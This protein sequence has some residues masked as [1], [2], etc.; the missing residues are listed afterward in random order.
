MQRLDPESLNLQNRKRYYEIWQKYKN[1]EQLEG[2][3]NTIA[4]LMA[5][6]KDWYH[7]W[8]STDFDYKFTPDVDGFDPFLH[9]TMDTI[10]MNQINSREPEQASFTYN[11]LTA[12]GDSHL[13]A[14]HKMAYMFTEEFFPVMKYGKTFN[15]KR[16]RR[17]LKELT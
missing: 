4:E 17:K 15:N 7:F 2:E 1:K 3:E 8:E 10:I 14:I 6:H 16:Y 5:L 13:E 9:V 12:R 11:K